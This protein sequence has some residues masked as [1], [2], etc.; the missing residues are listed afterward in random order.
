MV[1]HDCLNFQLLQRPFKRRI[2]KLE[3]QKNSEIAD[4]TTDEKKNNGQHNR[5]FLQLY[6]NENINKNK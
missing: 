1:I 6:S 3:K 4:M 2:S 5:N